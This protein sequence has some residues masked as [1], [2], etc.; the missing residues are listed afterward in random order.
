MSDT[1]TVVPAERPNRSPGGWEGMVW[2]AEDF[3]APLPD[4]I[5]RTFET[6]SDDGAAE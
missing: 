4:D 2:I 5:Q 3:D 1:T 6:S